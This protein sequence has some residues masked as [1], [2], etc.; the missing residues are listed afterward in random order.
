MGNKNNSAPMIRHLKVNKA[1]VLGALRW[2]K[3]HHSGYRDICIKE[4]NLDWMAGK[5]EANLSAFGKEVNVKPTRNSA[6]DQKEYV[7]KLQCQGDPD[8]CDDLE[9]TTMDAQ[10]A[11][12]QAR[13][14]QQC[15]P[16]NELAK[17]LKPDEQ[18]KMMY[19]PPHSNEPIK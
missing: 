1:R 2:L 4:E 7:S 18:D 6:K 5:D 10:E 14:E 13:G 19:F 11:P 9:F 16:L 3:V 15:Q 17:E 12:S 8:E